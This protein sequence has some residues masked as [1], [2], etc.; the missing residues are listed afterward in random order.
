MVRYNEG[1]KSLS[2]KKKWAQGYSKKKKNAIEEEDMKWVGC[3]EKRWR[4]LEKMITHPIKMQNGALGSIP[5][6]VLLTSRELLRL[7]YGEESSERI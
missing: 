7:I 2:I 6:P 3:D 5:Q 4:R 1:S